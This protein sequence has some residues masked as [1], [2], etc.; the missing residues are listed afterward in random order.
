MR[1]SGTK[2]ALAENTRKL[3][4]RWSLSET[5]FKKKICHVP[6]VGAPWR[7]MISEVQIVLSLLLHAMY[8]IHV[9]Y[10]TIMCVIYYVN[11]YYINIYFIYTHT[12]SPI[13]MEFLG[14]RT[15]GHTCSSSYEKQECQGRKSSSLISP[16]N[17]WEK[18]YPTVTSIHGLCVVQKCPVNPAF[19]LPP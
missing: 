2:D 5:C 13:C 8:L 16:L 1:L 9:I 15:I 3:I 6:R 18:N 17:V 14:L 4:A 10:L 19:N 7:Q 11:I 12:H